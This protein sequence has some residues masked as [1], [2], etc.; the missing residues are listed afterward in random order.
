MI[1]GGLNVFQFL[2]WIIGSEVGLDLLHSLEANAFTPL[3]PGFYPAAR[4]SVIEMGVVR[5][6]KVDVAKDIPDRRIAD[7]PVELEGAACVSAASGLETA[8]F[9]GCP[10]LFFTY[11]ARSPAALCA[12]CCW[13]DVGATCCSC[14]ADCSSGVGRC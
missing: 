9:C 6:R 7:V 5:R 4:E 12:C 14:I 1:A 13:N 11:E 8:R 10:P 3:D 2:G